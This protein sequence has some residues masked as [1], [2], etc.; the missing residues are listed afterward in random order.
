MI[1]L[2]SL[3]NSDPPSTITV[4]PCRRGTGM[5]AGWILRRS[6]VRN[7]T[8]FVLLSLSLGGC[9]VH[10]QETTRAFVGARIIP[11]AGPEIERGVLVVDGAKI[12]AVGAVDSVSIPSG[13]ERID[14]SGKVLMPGLVDTHSHI[15]GIGAADSSGPIQPDAREYDAINVRDSGFRRAVAGGLTTLNIMPGSGH[16]L[17]GQTVYVKLRGGNTIEDIMI[18]LPDGG[19][20][21]GIK[22]ANGTNSKREKPFPEA[23]AKSAALVRERY[24]KAQEY[25]DKL[26]KA[27][28]PEKAPPRDIGLEALVEV[29]EGKRIVHHHTHRHDDIITV[30]RLSKEFGF[31]V[32][33]HHVSE[34]WKVA[35]EIARAGAP[36]SVIQVDSPGGKLEAAELSFET[37]GV[38]E[39][40]GVKVAYHTDDWINDSR[41][42][43]REAALGVRA[44]MSREGALKSLTIHGAEMLDLGHRIGSLEPGKD[45]DFI[46]LSGDPLSLYTHVLQTWVEGRKVFDRDDPKDRLYAVGGYGAGREQQPYFCCFDREDQ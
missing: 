24:I 4:S 22:M 34:A 28:D 20:A 9:A 8:W 26:A 46:I 44:G 23:R 39:R 35:D 19:I 32:V 38:L 33:L 43:F 25:R 27:T 5:S 45:A 30:L 31:R 18:R 36:C 11:I 1:A 15:G 37:G 41:F 2:V 13:A 6:R 17:S 42:F 10:G 16:L 14:V 3:A 21:G 29:L 12:V 40:A 7:S